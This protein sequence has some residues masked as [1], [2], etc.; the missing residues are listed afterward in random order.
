VQSIGEPSEAL[1]AFFA[2]C[3]FDLASVGVYR[4]K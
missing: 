3:G 2:A 4:L 1:L